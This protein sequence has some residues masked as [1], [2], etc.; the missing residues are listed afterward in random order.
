MFVSQVLRQRVLDLERREDWRGL[1]ALMTTWRWPATEPP[2]DV[3]A[4]VFDVMRRVARSARAA[5]TL[6]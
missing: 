5:A 1:R 4:A 6:S 3:Q 2:L